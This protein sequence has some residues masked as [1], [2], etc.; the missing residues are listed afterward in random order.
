MHMFMNDEDMH[1]F[2][3]QACPQGEAF[4]AMGFGSI[5]GTFGEMMVLGALSN[6]YCY[7]GTT[8]KS[9][10]VV[11]TGAGNDKVN[12]VVVIPYGDITRLHIGSF[13]NVY[14]ID[15]Q[16]A[17]GRLKMTLAKSK[18]INKCERQKENAQ[19]IVDTLKKY[20]K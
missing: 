1:A 18:G 17:R 19:I 5:K 12:Q 7:M 15:V 2:M 8:E 6:Y 11:E 20:Q 3:A 14:N 16:T 9:L 13:L 4:T 10:V